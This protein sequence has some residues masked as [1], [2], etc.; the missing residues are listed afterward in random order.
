MNNNGNNNFFDLINAMSLIIG[1]QNLS[2]NREQSAHNNIQFENQKQAEFLLN[3]I[4]RQF[5]DIKS[6]FDEQNKTLRQI[7]KALQKIN[8]TE[9]NNIAD[10]RE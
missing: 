5:E 6:L 3:E 4:S 7:V 8:D 1:I 2:E 10:K 9:N